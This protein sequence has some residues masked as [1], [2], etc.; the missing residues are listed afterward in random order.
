[1]NVKDH[2]AAPK[3]HGGIG[4]SGGIVEELGEGIKIFLCSFCLEAR[5]IAECDHNLFFHCDGVIYEGANDGLDVG[6]VRGRE[7]RTVILGVGKLFFS[8]IFWMVPLVRC[9][10][11]F[12]GQRMFEFTEGLFD[13]VGN[14]Y[15]NV[16]ARVI[17]SKS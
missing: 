3:T 13:V 8:A 16:S 14:Q 2:A 15:I 5:Q 6:Y 12:R 4:I 1:M 9:I 7:D 10:L 11:W 17:P